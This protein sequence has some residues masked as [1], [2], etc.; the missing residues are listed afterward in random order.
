[1]SKT[2]SV[3]LEIAGPTAMWTR[4]DTGDAPVSYLA[5]TFSAAKGILESICWLKSAVVR[6][7]AVEICTPPIW[8][9]Y[10]TN[11]G[12]PLRKSSSFKD[13]NSFQLLATVLINV[14]YRI[15]AEVVN[16]DHDRGQSTSSLR[17]RK[18]RINGA[19]A[20]Q[21]MFKRKLERGQWFSMPSL[22]WREFVPD[23]VGPLR[24]MSKACVD[25]NMKLPSMLRT[26]FSEPSHGIYDPSFAQDVEIQQGIL[27]Y[28]K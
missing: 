4:P 21:E 15:H 3:E 8:H 14:C 17:Y 27:H 2:Y 5:P 6:P 10:T 20:Y 12:G 22:G 11:Y 9:T 25:V 19:H 1:V 24:E 7:T 26:V 28:A 18:T 23:Y 13:G 16:I